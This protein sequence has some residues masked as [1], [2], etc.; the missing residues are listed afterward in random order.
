MANGEWRRAQPHPCE[1]IDPTPTVMLSAPFL[2]PARGRGV[3][4]VEGCPFGECTLRARRPFYGSAPL[5][6]DTRNTHRRDAEDAETFTY[7][8]RSLRLCGLNL[9]E[10]NQP[11]VEHSGCIHGWGQCPLLIPPHAGEGFHIIEHRASRLPPL[12]NAPGCMGAFTNRGKMSENRGH[13]S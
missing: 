2:S 6:G 12:V 3:S 4:P 9:G 1:A 10:P 11:K 8:L 7:P 13:G 5:E